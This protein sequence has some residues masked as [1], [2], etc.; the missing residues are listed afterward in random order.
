MPENFSELSYWSIVPDMNIQMTAGARMMVFLPA[1][2]MDCYRP[3]VHWQLSNLLVQRDLEKRDGSGV[4]IH[5][6]RDCWYDV[7]ASYTARE[8]WACVVRKDRE[9][10]HITS[11]PSGDTGS[12]QTPERK[13]VHKSRLWRVRRCSTCKEKPNIEGH[14]VNVKSSKW[15]QNH[16][17]SESSES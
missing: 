8:S 2:T 13:F 1:S 16:Y 3:R 10:V 5:V 15:K 12:F 11:N 4:R 17:V 14:T 7:L 9:L 6:F